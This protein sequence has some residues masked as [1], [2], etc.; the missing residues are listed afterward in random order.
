MYFFFCFARNHW[1]NVLLTSSSELKVWP[2]R[3]TKNGNSKTCN[4]L[5]GGD[6]CVG[7]GI[8]W[9]KHDVINFCL[10]SQDEI[11]QGFSF[12]EMIW[13][14]ISLA[15]LIFCGVIPETSF[16]SEDYSGGPRFYHVTICRINPSSS[17][18]KQP[19]IFLETRLNRKS[20]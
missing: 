14:C 8:I 12:Q 9:V 2:L 17:P 13:F 3:C 18:S 4:S 11:L 16:C 19:R 6:T 20:S 10:L 15:L 7:P 1:R 5:S